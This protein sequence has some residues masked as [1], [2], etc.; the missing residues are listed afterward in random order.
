[1]NKNII[2]LA[3]VFVVP[4]FAYFML[5]KTNSA[6]VSVATGNRP[7]VIKFT[8]NMCSACKQMEPT[9]QKVMKKYQDTV[10]YTVIPVQVDNIY[11]RD[12]IN[13]YHVTLVPTIIILDKN[14]K[15]VKRIEGCVS[16]STLEN[17]IK[18]AIK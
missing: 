14:Q 12:L 2:I 9:I 4:L 1:M 10:Q 15:V 13:K 16:E 3:L 8:S 6:S 17:Y 11:N 5:S 18:G 7:H